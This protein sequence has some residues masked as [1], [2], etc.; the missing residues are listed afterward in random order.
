MTGSYLNVPAVIIVFIITA[1]LVKGISESASFNALMVFIK[2]AAVLFVVLVVNPLG[3]EA[4]NRLGQEVGEIGHL[5]AIGDFRLP[6]ATSAVNHLA[7]RT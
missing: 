7:C 1:V 5:E 2:V 4:A 6:R 3:G